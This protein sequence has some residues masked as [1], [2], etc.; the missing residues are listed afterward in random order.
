MVFK[1]DQQAL[2]IRDVARTPVMSLHKVIMVGDSHILLIKPDIKNGE[3]WRKVEDD[4]TGFKIY[5]MTFS[6]DVGEKDENGV[7]VP[8]EEDYIQSCVTRDRDDPMLSS[9]QDHILWRVVSQRA[10]KTHHHDHPKV[11]HYLNLWGRHRIA[12]MG[13]GVDENDEEWSSRPV[14]RN[15]I[16]QY[17]LRTDLPSGELPIRAVYVAINDNIPMAYHHHRDPTVP[18]PSMSQILVGNDSPFY[19]NSNGTDALSFDMVWSGGSSECL[20]TRL[21][22]FYFGI[23]SFQLTETSSAAL[24]RGAAEPLRYHLDYSSYLKQQD[25]KK[26][27]REIPSVQ[28][29]VLAVAQ[30]NRGM[31]VAFDVHGDERMSVYTAP[32]DENN[33][34]DLVMCVWGSEKLEELVS[35]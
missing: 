22:T 24:R 19:L 6:L 15:E 1:F 4:P 25:N 32:R 16:H 31:V 23:R 29:N 3:K 18:K 12:R 14:E 27:I 20:G 8:G 28:R 35:V 5:V 2:G 17:E 33:V 11:K 10:P 21:M 26:E 13:K 7:V 9:F 34:A 30:S